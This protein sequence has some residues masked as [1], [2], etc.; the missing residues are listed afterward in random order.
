MASIRL[1][2][3][4]FT[5]DKVCGV[6]LGV[7]YAII[8]VFSYVKAHGARG[9]V[10]ATASQIARA[11]EVPQ[12]TVKAALATTFFSCKA[13][14]ITVKDWEKMEFDKTTA[15][16]QQQFRFNLKSVTTSPRTNGRFDKFWA[17]YPNKKK[18]LYARAIFE[19]LNPDDAFVDRM[20]AAIE[21]QKLSRQWIRD[22]G[23]YIPHP[24]TWLNG[25][26]WDDEV[27]NK[28]ESP[29]E[30][31]ARWERENDDADTK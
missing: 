16:R 9:T 28:D 3:D 6:T 4:F 22:N 5:H 15:A 27:D 2:T 26:C 13:S 1:D 7:R 17:A 10:E 29:T 20:I 12:R 24:S 31:L 21:E 11:T 18:K 8:A 23:E 14:R 19:R 25:G 30:L